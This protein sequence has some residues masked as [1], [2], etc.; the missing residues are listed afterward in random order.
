M[1]QDA[2]R[3]REAGLSLRS[4]AARLGIS[5]STASVWTREVAPPPPASPAPV[6]APPEGLRRCSRCARDR[7]ASEF[8]RYRS[9]RQW[10]CRDCFPAYY[11]E[12]R[13]HHRA[14]TNALKARRVAE[15]QAYVM[16]VL[17]RRACADC[18]Q[19]DAIVLE[20]DHV[21]PKRADVATLVRR[22]VRLSVLDAE[23]EQCEV[24]CANCH[25]RRT[26]LR[27]GWR[28]L[29]GDLRDM[30]WRSPRHERNVRH[31]FAV[32]QASRCADCGEADL[33]V[34]DFAHVGPKSVTIMRLARNEA[35]QARL[36][37]EIS[38]CVVRCATAIAGGRPRSPA[39]TAPEYPQRESNS[40]YH[41]ER[42]A[43]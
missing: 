7:P 43:C 15:A 1:R 14:R 28:R 22:G 41:R 38:S 29:D 23:I 13:A 10:W 11:A 33:C 25:R 36:Q 34:L 8:N 20:F 3:L 27:A 18:G 2:R 26:A 32:L 37:A 6:S 21:G 31:V 4:I 12:R 24:V 17:R 30:R 39:T 5:L 40:R 9:G 42:V 35:S 19:A 16:E